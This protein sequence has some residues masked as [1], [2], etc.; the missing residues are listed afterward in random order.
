MIPKQQG[1]EKSMRW[2]NNS[3]VRKAR[4]VALLAG[5]AATICP[6]LAG[7]YEP[8]PAGFF[9]VGVFLQPVENFDVWKS[10][11]VNTVVDFWPGQQPLEVWNAAAV[12]RGLYMIRAPR[13]NNL[14]QD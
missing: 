5:V 14:A 10:R 3:I 6:M 8:P 13:F 7:A 11:G 2:I 1:R 12:Q 4:G 9:P